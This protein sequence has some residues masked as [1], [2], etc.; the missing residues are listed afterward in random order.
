MAPT[1]SIK[2]CRRPVWMVWTAAIVVTLLGPTSLS[3]NPKLSLAAITLASC[4]MLMGRVL[5]VS[6]RDSARR[7]RRVSTLLGLIA[8]IALLLL[9]AAQETVFDGSTLAPTAETI[10]MSFSLIGWIC[11]SFDEEKTSGKPTTTVSVL[12]ASFALPIGASMLCHALPS[13]PAYLLIA[14]AIALVPTMLCRSSKGSLGLSEPTLFSLF[15]GMLLAASLLEMVSK[16][17]NVP[18][19]F[20]LHASIVGGICLAVTLN[21]TKQ[22]SKEDVSTPSDDTK[23]RIVGLALRPLSERELA[24]LTLTALGETR[25]DIAAKLSI[26]EST[27]GTNRSRGYEKLGISS[28]K[29]LV[30]LLGKPAADVTSQVSEN[31]SDERTFDSPALLVFLILPLLGAIEGASRV[32]GLALIGFALSAILSSPDSGG[33]RALRHHAIFF[34]RWENAVA[35]LLCTTFV[36]AMSAASKTLGMGAL[37]QALL[38]FFLSVLYLGASAT[39]IDEGMLVKTRIMRLARTGV[40]E[41]AYRFQE[42]A[43]ISGITLLSGGIISSFALNRPGVLDALWLLI[44]I[45]GV[46]AFGMVFRPAAYLTNK[47]D[48]LRNRVLAGLRSRGLSDI[49]AKMAL[50]LA[51]GDSESSIC[52]ELHVARGTV[53]SYRSKIYR[54]FDVHSASELRKRLFQEGGSTEINR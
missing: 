24:T 45:Y 41:L 2:R 7:C 14:A 19:A 23:N 30:A 22:E 42:L 37:V 4:A 53:K 21:R 49:Q 51:Q 35:A 25:R 39:P 18:M 11:L 54:E 48:E 52:Q 12:I 15:G 26:S 27:V 6:D 3:A 17:V 38:V 47:E 33:E 44:I 1:N 36:P 46:L 34:P 40:G 43:G 5:G 8:T 28:K 20:L 16:G 31:P 29:E 32:V 9:A 50:L 13:H 10:L